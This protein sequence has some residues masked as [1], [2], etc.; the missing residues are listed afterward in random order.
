[1]NDELIIEI[2]APS[3]IYIMTLI[4]FFFT[5]QIALPRPPR[6]SHMWESAGTALLPI[7][8]RIGAANPG[9]VF[10]VLTC[11]KRTR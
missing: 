1:M 9:H 8:Q 10:S 5:K 11:V 7:T 3:M 6:D 2:Y 4:T